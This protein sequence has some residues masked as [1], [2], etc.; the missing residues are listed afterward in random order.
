M[1]TWK[2]RDLSL[3]VGASFSCMARRPLPYSQWGH[4]IFLVDAQAGLRWGELGVTIKTFNLLG[5]D[6]YDGEFM[7]A[8]KW[9]RDQA[10]ALV[11][12]RHVGVGAPRGVFA[13]LEL[14]L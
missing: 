8:S 2:A 11:P 12:T 6:W 3:L 14:Y 7:F 13:S 9:D 1:A 10:A 4:D 5:A